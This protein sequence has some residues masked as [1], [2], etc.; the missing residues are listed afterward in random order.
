MV[1]LT[2]NHKPMRRQAVINYRQSSDPVRN[3]NFQFGAPFI[4]SPEAPNP[5]DLMPLPHKIAAALKAKAD[6]R[7]AAIAAIPS[8]LSE[9]DRFNAVFKIDLNSPQTT[10]AQQLR[11]IGVHIPSVEA[12][13]EVDEAGEPVNSL[14]II[15]IQLWAVIY[16]LA[17]LGVYLVDTN[18][19]TDRQLLRRLITGPLADEIP[20]IVP[21]RDCVEYL[22]FNSFG[23]GSVQVPGI[24]DGVEQMFDLARDSILPT[25]DREAL[26]QTAPSYADN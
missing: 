23:L 3:P 25:P 2:T 22:G 7:A 14:P 5:A 24:V 10:N 19:L 16:G 11:D 18:H 9:L 17:T 13:D 4:W 1:R 15:H 26:D 20:D 21:N 6:K 8:G 12:I